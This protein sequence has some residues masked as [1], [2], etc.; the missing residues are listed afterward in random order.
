MYARSF[1]K[2]LNS[3]VSSYFFYERLAMSFD[4]V[5]FEETLGTSVV[6]S[7][8]CIGCGACV[9]VCPFNCL[10]Y[11][12]EGPNLVKECQVCGICAQVCPKYE[13]SWPKVEDFVFGRERK[14]EEEFGVYRRLVVA[15]AVD[16]GMVK[17]CQDGGVV[18]ALLLFALENGLIDSA[19]VSGIS[20]EK[21]L[22]PAPRLATTYEEILE[23]AGTRYFY[24]PNILALTEGIK[25]KK[26]S[27]AFV[28]TP[29]QIR[30]IRKMQMCGLKKHT[31]P[32][33]FLIGLM[34]SECFTYEGLAE[35]HIR[36]TLGL[37]LNDI[38]KINIKGKI[39]VKTK[40]EVRTIPL[41]TAK[42]YGRKSCRFCD[43]FSS[44]LADISTGGL[45]LDG[46][47]FIIIR[48]ER[49]ENL[50][51]NAEKAGHL[52]VKTVDA[53]T[54]A[55]NLLAKLSRKKRKT[56]EVC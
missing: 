33:M 35:K 47:T 5:S 19:V 38:T 6:A 45:G 48:T 39:L 34:C 36:D 10:E 37:N 28:G 52:Y 26:T 56:R 51:S 7:G 16:D 46:W 12:K 11:M 3:R 13:W 54:Y 30:A 27:T 18:T 8:K 42:Q 9:V 14:A 25:Q 21:P 29:C 41:A 50:F 44:E 43:D 31:K 23:C 15:R 17:L 24:S 22:Y 49:G 32:L 53:E 1:Q 4:K 2:A 20:P 40:S 55:L